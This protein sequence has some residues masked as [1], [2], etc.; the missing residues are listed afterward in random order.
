MSVEDQ[1]LDATFDFKSNA[2]EA[3]RDGL[4]AQRDALLA[5]AEGVAKELRLWKDSRGMGTW[6]AARMKADAEAQAEVL[7]SAIAACKE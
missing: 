2:L 3:E 1:E 7:E 4:K 6:S 5:A